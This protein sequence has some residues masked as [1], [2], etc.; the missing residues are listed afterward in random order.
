MHITPI[1]NVQQNSFTGKFQKTQAL[2]K[3]ID[4]LNETDLRLFSKNKQ[5][6]EKVNNN[7][8]YTYELKSIDQGTY[9]QKR[10]VLKEN[11]REIYTG[12]KSEW[13]SKTA[14]ET[15]I[16]DYPGA[17]K[18]V[19]DFLFD[20]YNPDRKFEE[21]FAYNNLKNKIDKLKESI[22]SNIEPAD[23]KLGKIRK[24]I[25]LKNDNYKVT[26]G[27]SHNYKVYSD[28]GELLQE[29]GPYTGSLTRVKDFEKGKVIREYIC[30]EDY[31]A[32]ERVK[33]IEN[34]LLGS[35][36]KVYDDGTIGEL[37]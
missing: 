4:S 21:N 12:V 22:L 3:Y 16:K 33:V 15:I 10:A 18:K 36:R 28:N 27:K 9:G 23:F 34:G 11:G 1:N 5:L 24:Q 26:E 20:K 32:A 14:N 8:I 13:H 25:L 17:E 29:Y 35:W 31:T 19:F 37:F 30:N 2:I 6:M 7:K